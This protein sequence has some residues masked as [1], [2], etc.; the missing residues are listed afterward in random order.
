MNMRAVRF[1]L[2]FCGVLLS[3][4]SLRASCGSSSCPLDL[5]ALNAPIVGQ[6][7]FDL[8][9]QY[10]DQNRPMIGTRAARIGEIETD[11]AEVKTLNR[12]ITGVLAYSPAKNLQV[13]A[14]VPWMSRSHV[15][16]AENGRESWDLSGIGDISLQSRYR[17][18]S[19]G[20]GAAAGLWLITGIKLPT[21]AHDRRNKAG[22]VAE[23]PIQPGSGTTDG[24][25][26]LSWQGGT[27]RAM[28]LAGPMGNYGVVPFFATATYQARTGGVNGYR[29]GNE[30]Q[31]NAGTGYPLTKDV[32]LLFQLNSRVQEKDRGPDPRETAFTGGTHIY[33]SPGLRFAVRGVG[34]YAI[35]QL[36]LYQRVNELQLTS[37]TNVIIGLQHRFR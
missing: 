13:S 17:F 9:W 35:V 10:L 12:V 15:H 1:A 4:T 28:A 33:A 21:G 27:S 6:V 32:V 34:A 24:I 3:I 7:G 25:V 5:N 36:P 26:G 31:V 23:L 22:E 14:T 30:L 2:G 19:G 18:V 37:R 16:L 11:H 20:Q 29:I 8:S